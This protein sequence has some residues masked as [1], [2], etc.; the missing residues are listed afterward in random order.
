MK[1]K[2]VKSLFVCML[3][4]CAAAF[5]GGCSGTQTFD[6]GVYDLAYSTARQSA[7][8]IPPKMMVLTIDGDTVSWNWINRVPHSSRPS[9]K[10]GDVE[11]RIAVPAGSHTFTMLYKTKE[12]KD[13]TFDLQAGVSYTFAYKKKQITL[14]EA[15][16]EVENEK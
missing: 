11:T 6:M 14:V 4:I 13:L 10:W 1:K 3:F 8:I 12:F 7:L 5:F 15:P 9:G 16:V 2:S